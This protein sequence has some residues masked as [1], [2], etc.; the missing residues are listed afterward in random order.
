[1]KTLNLEKMTDLTGG[2][3]VVGN[4]ISGSCTAG[5]AWTLAA[6]LKL[7]AAIALPSGVGQAA[8]VICIGNWAGQAAGWW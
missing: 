2:G 1:M 8:A 5:G 6:S 7:V 4:I 3:T